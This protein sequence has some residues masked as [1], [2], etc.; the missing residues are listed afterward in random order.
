[1]KKS[2]ILTAIAIALASCC[3]GQDEPL[4]INDLEYFEKQ[5]VNVLVYSNLFTG[6]FNDEKNSGIEII[7]HGVRTAQGGAIRLVTTPEQWDLVPAA[8]ERTVDRENNEIGVS[9]RYEDYDF[10]SRV[11]VTGNGDSFEIAVYLDEPVPENLVGRAGFNLEFLPS[12]YWNKSYIVDG[13]PERFPRYT[14]SETVT[15]PNSMKDKQF[16]GYR[17]YDDRG[18]GRFVEPLPLSTGHE[19]VLAPEDPE[20]MIKITSD[21]ELNLYD[22]RMLAQNGWYVLRTLLPAGQTGKVVSWIVEPNAIEGWVREPNIGF[23]QVGY[24]PDQPKVAVI[25]LDKTDKVHKT[26]SL[27]KVDNDGKISRAYTGKTAEWGRYYKYNYVHF[28]FSGVTEPG[29]YYIRYGDTKTNNFIIGD[30]V[31]DK[32]T[33]A[34]SDIW[35]PIHMNHVTVNEGYRIWH[36]EPFREGYLQA[37]AN[38]DHFDLHWQDGSTNTKY[39]PLELIPGLNVGGYFRCGRLR[40]RD[41]LEHQRRDKPRENLGTLPSYARHDFRG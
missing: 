7:H 27:Y 18:T 32:I 12:Q 19:M 15:L 21:Q 40:H 41:G 30:N 6:G 39:K 20:R 33:E 2:F 14:V 29:V 17:T 36:G 16:K 24:L 34:T 22:G 28:D 31:Y 13:K 3:G 5:G 4:K 25:E 11:V 37:P 8:P 1:M 38:T 35:I 9:L 26:A 10:D 23:S